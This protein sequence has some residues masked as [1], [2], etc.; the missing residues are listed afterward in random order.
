M[1]VSLAAGPICFHIAGLKIQLKRGNLMYAI[2]KYVLEKM[3]EK[4][5]KKGEFVKRLGYSNISKGC[6]RFDL[7]LAGRSIRI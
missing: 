7:F 2:Q 5:L 3:K 4:N 1:P 6:R